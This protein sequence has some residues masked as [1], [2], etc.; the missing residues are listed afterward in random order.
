VTVTV[1]VTKIDSIKLS[2]LLLAGGFFFW[3]DKTFSATSHYSWPPRR[4]QVRPSRLYLVIMLLDLGC[5][6]L[7]HWSVLLTSEIDI[8]KISQRIPSAKED[9][10][11]SIQGDCMWSNMSYGVLSACGFHPGRMAATQ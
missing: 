5:S 6:G 4:E 2:L 9:E 10:L 7:S 8:Y 11:A 1:T 3:T